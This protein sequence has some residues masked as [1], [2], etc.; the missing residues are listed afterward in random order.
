MQRVTK[1]SRI[2]CGECVSGHYPLAYSGSLTFVP[3]QEE[4]TNWLKKLIALLA[5]FSI[6][7][8]IIVIF[9][10]NVFS[11]HHHGFV[12]FSQSISPP[13]IGCELFNGPEIKQ[14]DYFTMIKVFGSFFSIWNLDIFCSFSPGICLRLKAGDIL[15]LDFGVGMCSFIAMVTT[16]FVVQLYNHIYMSI[17]LRKLMREVSVSK[18]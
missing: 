6:F 10:V 13:A 5:P 14:H 12:Y 9:E 16:Y 17:W 1:R 4:F 2:L 15:W 18:I 7:C 8:V 3:C 11:S